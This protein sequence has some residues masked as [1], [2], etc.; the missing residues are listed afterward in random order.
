MLCSVPSDSWM[1]LFSPYLQEE[2]KGKNLR[3]PG[4][5]SEGTLSLTSRLLSLAARILII[6]FVAKLL[7]FS[8]VNI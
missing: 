3:C 7:Y 6:V 4:V 5:E 8:M 2:D 1:I